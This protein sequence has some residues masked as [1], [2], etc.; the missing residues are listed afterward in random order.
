[1]KWNENNSIISIA[2]LIK[3]CLHLIADFHS[4]FQGDELL[5]I[6]A[7]NHLAA[8]YMEFPPFVGFIAWIQNLT[9]SDSVFVHHV[10]SHLASLAIIVLSGKITLELGGKRKA[11]I[12]VLIFILAAPA[13]T[14]THQLF[15]PVVFS[16]LFWMLG[17]FYLVK[18]VKTLNE[19]YL[20]FLALTLAAGFLNKY[21][22]LV[23]SC[24]LISLLFFQRT[25]VAILKKSSIIYLLIFIVIVSP[26]IIWQITN[27]FPVL[28]H[29]RELYES[30]LN[31]QSSSKVLL[32]I[33]V[34]LNPFAVLIYITGFVY[35][36]F[37]NKD[38]QGRAI[39]FSILISILLLVILKSKSYYYFP[40]II[41]L[42]I[43]GSIWLENALFKK[44]KWLFFPLIILLIL[45][46]ALM[47]P[48]GMSLMKLEKF[49]AYAD[50]KED[51]NGYPIEFEEFYSQY[52]WEKVLSSVQII[53]E[54]L[55]ENEKEDCVIWGKHYKQAGA[56]NL[57][58][59][60]YETP[61]AISYHGSY[62][63]WA[64]EKGNLPAAVISLCN[65]GVPKEFWESFFYSV[66]EEDKI[67]NPY[68]DES[69][70]EWTYIYVCRDPKINYAGLKEAFKH[71]VFE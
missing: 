30:Q 36:I 11:L 59:D 46:G 2:C 37:I 61:K 50:M 18:F 48:Y 54:N 62:Y 43:L 44:R 19:R 53:F 32:E 3:I 29:M 7:G 25:R 41:C 4:G 12:L 67:P 66:E 49:I 1:M 34:Q 52:Q 22:I 70:D 28:D 17:F 20:L 38:N 27:S 14:R 15:Q 69:E 26:N 55:P 60:K 16:Q 63:N 56:I 8:G 57:F 33:F 42:I 71:R 51:N 47:L 9:G 58:S 10:F 45:S 13:F 40:A 5:H 65:S 6:D 68:A 31:R 35:A 24:G 64:P 23:F 39:S 21:D